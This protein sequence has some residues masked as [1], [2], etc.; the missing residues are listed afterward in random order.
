MRDEM[1]NCMHKIKVAA[2]F[3]TNL[4]KIQSNNC[5]R[6]FSTSQ[7]TEFANYEGQIYFVLICTI[8]C[9]WFAKYK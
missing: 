4:N 8:C 7:S 2:Y 3:S 1:K 6:N 9:N 5:R